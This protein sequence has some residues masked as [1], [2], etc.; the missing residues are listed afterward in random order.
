MHPNTPQE[1]RT[2]IRKLRGK[3]W[4]K[5]GLIDTP[6][7]TTWLGMLGR[8][9]NPKH[10]SYSR[11]GGK[12]IRVCDDWHSYS[13]FYRDMCP[14]PSQ[15]LQLDRIDPLG[16]YSKDNCRWVTKVEQARNK[17]NTVLIEFRGESK[18][19]GEWATIVGI[20]RLTLWQRLNLYGWSVEEAF[21]LPPQRLRRKGKR[22]STGL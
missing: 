4:E 20:N 18:T 14:K 21:T 22:S 2:E 17:T 1:R 7:Y 10:S 8:C 3:S 16:P 9:H 6:E 15:E 5:H 12:G 19:L 13:N 11:Y